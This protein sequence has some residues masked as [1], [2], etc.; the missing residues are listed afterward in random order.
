MIRRFKI[1]RTTVSAGL[2]LVGIVLGAGA[3]EMKWR[4]L[5]PGTLV[6]EGTNIT[7]VYEPKG[8]G[9]FHV[10]IGDREKYPYTNLE[11]AKQDAERF[12]KELV[13]IGVQ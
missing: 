4:V 12:Y 1:F 3:M 9:D 8:N 13:E 6:L 2:L 10:Y 11:S 5:K 7:I